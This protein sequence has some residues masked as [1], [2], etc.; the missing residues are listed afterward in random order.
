MSEPGS[1]E[2]DRS[3]GEPVVTFSVPETSFTLDG[4]R[5][6]ASYLTLVAD[7]A[8]ARPEP[9]VEE[10]VAVLD[11]TDARLLDWFQASREL[12]RAVLAAG[13]KREIAATGTEGAALCPAPVPAAIPVT[14]MSTT[15]RGANAVCASARGGGVT[16]TPGSWSRSG[17]QRGKRGVTPWG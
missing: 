11:A 7:E 1:I 13:Y 5:Q 14:L 17:K 4:L 3:G 9:E 12:A 10:L 2:I 16:G 8:S 15:A 6:F